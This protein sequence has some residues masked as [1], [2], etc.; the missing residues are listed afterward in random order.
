MTNCIFRLRMP[1]NMSA[2]RIPVARSKMFLLSL[3]K[4]SAVAPANPEEVLRLIRAGAN[5]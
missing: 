4:C 2:G 1:L 3:A 5:Q